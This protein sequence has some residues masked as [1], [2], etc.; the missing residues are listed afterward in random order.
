MKFYYK[1]KLIR[2]SK[3]HDYNWAILQEKPDGTYRCFGCRRDRSDA[4][5]EACR[6]SRLGHD[7]LILAPL[8]KRN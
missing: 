8:E 4:D 1:E 6:L 5:S 7:Q 2:T 3:N